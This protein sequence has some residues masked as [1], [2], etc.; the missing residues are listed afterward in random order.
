[1]LIFLFAIS[2]WSYSQPTYHTDIEPL[3]QLNCVS[4]HKPGGIGPFSLQTYEE[5]KAKGSFIG[6]VT[7]TKYMP[8][9]K[10]DPTYQTFRNEKKL[11]P[12]EIDLIQKWIDSGMPKG[13]K[14][15]SKKVYTPLEDLTRPDLTLPMISSYQL[16]EK[17]VED[18]RFFV[19]PSNLP[20]D[21]Y[22][23]AV[24]F[25]PGNRKQVHHSRV[26]VDSTQKIRGIDGMSELDPGVKK[27][28]TIP[29]ADEFLYGWVP[30]NTKIFFPPGAAKKLGK[31]SDLILNIH[32]SPSSKPQQDKS[33]VN[34]YYAKT[35]VTREVYTLTLREN[36]IRNQP[37]YIDAERMPTFHI[38]YPITKDISLISVMPHMHFI[39]KSFLAY[40]ITLEGEKIPLIKIDNWDFNWQTTYQF[41]RLL[42]IPAGSRIYVEAKYDNTSENPANPNNPAK[43][44]GYGWNST[45][46]MC[47]LVIYYIDYKEGD[48]LIEY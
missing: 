34:L 45:D 15:K 23:S 8:P 4:C 7:K 27:F 32:Y 44:I 19:V 17:A 43:D 16:S 30:G 33:V 39:G 14:V 40:A 10:A 2:E 48:E 12:D 25:V 11:T 21:T 3:I 9:W 1:M 37:F 42:K 38:D 20:A 41:K 31:G 47:N 18:F 22:I 26:M 6:H 13:K 46:E 29:L 36:D 24:E 5:V 35:P 28:Q